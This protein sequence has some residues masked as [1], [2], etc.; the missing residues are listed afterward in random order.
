ML[1]V[2]PHVEAKLSKEPLVW[3]GTWEVGQQ[4]ATVIVSTV[5]Y[6]DVL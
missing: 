1:L 3:C 6:A 4:W 5:I 2:S